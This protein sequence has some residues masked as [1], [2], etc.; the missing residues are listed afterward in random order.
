M[1]LAA[2]LGPIRSTTPRGAGVAN[3]VSSFTA[4]L[5]DVKGAGLLAR[6]RIFYVSVFT[7]LVL[8]LGGAITG[9]ILLGDSWFQLII[10]GVLGIIFTQFAFL[11]HEASHRQVFESG[12]AN[13]RIGRV[14]SSGIV[15]ISYSWWMNKHTRHHANPNMIGKDPDIAIDV[16]SF[17]EQDAASARGLRALITRHQAALFFPFLLFEGVNLHVKSFGHIFG[18]GKVDGRAL[19]IAL[20]AARMAIVVGAVFWVLPVGMAFAF[21]GVQLAVFGVYMGMSFAPNHIGMEVVPEGA[22]L[23]F[24]NKQ[25]LTGRNVTGGFWM[26]AFMGGLNFQIEHHLF[27]SM[28]R[29]HLRQTRKLV[30]EVCAR[31]G[32]PYTETSL[33]RAYAIVL[34]YLREIGL[35]SGLAT[36]DC[37]M[38]GQ[39]RRV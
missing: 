28:A 18:R 29:P 6:A 9:F 39:Y 35:Y 2:T 31:E 11:G 5:S 36:F 16:I 21:L 4:L 25:V 33:G 14:L 37:P 20:I 34:T 7:T 15:G 26:T 19:E 8:A 32:I 17:V 38:V 23:D 1:S 13:D 30:R 27:P 10:A 22:K 12:R 24:L 3:P